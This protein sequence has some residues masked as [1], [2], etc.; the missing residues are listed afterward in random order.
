MPIL[1]KDDFMS[2]LKTYIGEDTSDE[3]VS[4]IEDVTD[5]FN[6]LESRTVDNSSEWEEKYNKLSA[7][8]DELDKYSIVHKIEGDK[9]TIVLSN[10][11]DNKKIGSCNVE[12]YETK[13]KKRI[14][15]KIKEIFT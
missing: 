6:D 1:N 8:K 13:N 4:F 10:E 3:T 14:F 11:N 15:K 5:T 9:S 7:E 2:R 12:K